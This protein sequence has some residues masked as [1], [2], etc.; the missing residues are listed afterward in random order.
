MDLSDW[1]KSLLSGASFRG[2][3]GPCVIDGGTDEYSVTLA[4][5][6]ILTRLHQWGNDRVLILN[7]YNDKDP[8]EPNTFQRISK[9]VLVIVW[10]KEH[11]HTFVAFPEVVA[12]ND[13]WMHT[14]GGNLPNLTPP[15]REQYHSI[16][17]HLHHCQINIR[18]GQNPRGYCGHWALFVVMFAA[19]LN[20]HKLDGSARM[21]LLD[22]KLNMFYR[23]FDDIERARCLQT[24]V[25][26]FFEEI[27]SERDDTVITP[28]TETFLRENAYY[29]IGQGARENV[30]N[31]NF[32]AMNPNQL[33]R[34]NPRDR[35]T[36]AGYYVYFPHED[37]QVLRDDPTLP[38][39]RTINIKF[40]VDE[41]HS[42]VRLFLGDEL[43]EA[44]TRPDEDLTWLLQKS[45]S[46]I[47]PKV[48]SSIHLGRGVATAARKRTRKRTH[49][50]QSQ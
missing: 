41:T 37:M 25:C 36:N 33:R 42:A 16:V 17:S 15:F 30:A 6:Y 3:R 27:R 47:F 46:R 1:L 20:L 2:N 22:K 14:F 24:L 38:P 18:Q 31:L 49:T 23:Q 19:L 44:T 21:P 8:W 29:M 50:I 4:Q 5:K 7:H 9:D 28:V 48:F 12:D 26:D 45:N 11:M 13:I 40:G 43:V 35:V 34:L 32:V 39:V 10:V